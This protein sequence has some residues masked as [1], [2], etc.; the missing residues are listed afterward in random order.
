MTI[1]TVQKHRQK[2]LDSSLPGS[3]ERAQNGLA[4]RLIT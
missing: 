3:P 4:I 2:R 1:A